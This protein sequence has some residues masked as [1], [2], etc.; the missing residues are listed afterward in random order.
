MNKVNEFHNNGKIY[1]VMR[2]FATR[3]WFG[4][5]STCN[6]N[7]FLPSSIIIQQRNNYRFWPK[8]RC[9]LNHSG[10]GFLKRCF[11]SRDIYWFKKYDFCCCIFLFSLALP[12]S[13]FPCPYIA[14][15]YINK[16]FIPY[17]K[18][19]EKRKNCENL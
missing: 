7:K 3:Y 15:K 19:E 6:F 2:L 12:F 13:S 9:P 8:H 18:N 10:A 16:G 1:S 11:P 17:P 5:S 4:Q 14:D